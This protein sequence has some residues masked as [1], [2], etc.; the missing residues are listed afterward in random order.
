MKGIAS[1]L[2]LNKATHYLVILLDLW[3]QQLH[4]THEDDDI[5]CSINITAL[6]SVIADM[7]TLMFG[8]SELRP[9]WPVPG[10][11]LLYLGRCIIADLSGNACVWC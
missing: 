2:A 1:F 3:Q 9:I 4:L 6:W 7:H 8:N 10:G 11:C 5:G